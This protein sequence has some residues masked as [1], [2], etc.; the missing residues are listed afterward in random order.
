MKSNNT[1]YSLKQQNI[2][3][4]LGENIKLARLR[5]KFSI[6]SLAERA[7]I[8]ISTLANIEKGSPSVSL[9]NYLQV[10]T[11]LRLD[12]DLLLVAD[13]DLVGRQIQDSELV[14]RKRAP[15]EK[16]A[17]SAIAYMIDDGKSE[18]PEFE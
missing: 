6:R 5:R 4:R 18:E 9:G 11:V 8:A 10:L 7:G 13:T 2:L 17:P 12:D 3:T 15:K 1:N 16:N 14:A